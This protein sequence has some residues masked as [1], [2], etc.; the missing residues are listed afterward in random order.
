MSAPSFQRILETLNRHGV[1]F[2]VVGGVAAVLHGAPVTTFDLDAL[3]RIN[4]ENARR[5]LGALAELD[6]R[7]R[8][9]AA[10]MRPTLNDVLAGGHMLLLTSAGPLD[11]LGYI[12]KHQRFEDLQHAVTQLNV[13]TLRVPVLGLEELIRQKKLL[14]RD[15]DEPALRM[16]EE[17]LKRQS[18]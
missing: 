9:Q 5:L 13:A 17:V 8:E 2:V 11:V 10:V 7:Y 3:V 1:E 6:A 15:K 16:L 4:E 18:G 14:S 12:G